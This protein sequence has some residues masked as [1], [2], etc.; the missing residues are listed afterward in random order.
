MVLSVGQWWKKSAR[1]SG[2]DRTSQWSDAQSDFQPWWATTVRDLEKVLPEYGAGTDA[3]G[4]G[5]GR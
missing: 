2:A 1:W 4:S 3:A 5:M